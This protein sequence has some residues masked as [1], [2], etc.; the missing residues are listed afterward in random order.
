MAASITRIIG[1]ALPEI[2]QSEDATEQ[3]D[4]FFQEFAKIK[5]TATA[6]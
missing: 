4:R 1:K 3:L 2:I 6:Q 5:K